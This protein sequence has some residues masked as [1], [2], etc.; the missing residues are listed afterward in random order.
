MAG[1]V[2]ALES[3]ETVAVVEQEVGFHRLGRPQ[4]E[5]MSEETPAEPGQGWHRCPSGEIFCICLMHRD[6]GSGRSPELGDISGMIGMG[7][8][9]DD[10]FEVARI[11]VKLVSDAG[12]DLLTIADESRVD[13]DQ[14]ISVDQI[15]VP[16]DA[17]NPMDVR[18]EFHFSSPPCS[19]ATSFRKRG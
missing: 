5:Q 10:E 1:R 8:G 9:D 2:D 6:P 13:Q 14:S 4:G 15:A 3:G 19:N 17:V 7:V 12:E 16:L 18:N 11:A